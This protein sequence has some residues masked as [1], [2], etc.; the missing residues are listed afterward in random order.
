[1]PPGYPPSGGGLT[2]CDF[3]KKAKHASENM[4]RSVGTSVF[5]AQSFENFPRSVEIKNLVS[6]VVAGSSDLG[7]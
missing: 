2:A 4:T 5:M 1:L 3:D 6:L 7:G